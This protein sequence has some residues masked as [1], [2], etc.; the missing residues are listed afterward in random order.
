MAY[1]FYFCCLF[2]GS[3]DG[4]ADLLRAWGLVIWILFVAYLV[5]WFGFCG[6]VVAVV[7]CWLQ[8]LLIG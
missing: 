3:F 5:G 7:C 6:V 2:C 4:C 1:V 8:T